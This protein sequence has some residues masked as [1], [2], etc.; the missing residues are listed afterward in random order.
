MS[1]TRALFIGA[2]PGG[3]NGQSEEAWHMKRR[4]TPWRMANDTRAWE[5]RAW[6]D[7]ERGWGGLEECAVGPVAFVR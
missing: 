4:H 6:V 2:L 7:G 5:P 3:Q 1:G